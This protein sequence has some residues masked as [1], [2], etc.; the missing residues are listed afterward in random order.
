MEKLLVTQTLTLTI[1]CERSSD[2]APA[3]AG[4]RHSGI[5]LGPIR[6]RRV[7]HRPP[8]AGWANPAS[9]KTRPPRLHNRVLGCLAVVRWADRGAPPSRPHAGNR[10]GF[11]RDRAV[12]RLRSGAPSLL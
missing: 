3:G 12:E 2:C 4:Y 6:N 5:A 8:S 7:S 11:A 1:H 10:R 9:P